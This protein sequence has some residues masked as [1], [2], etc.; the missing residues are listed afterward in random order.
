MSSENDSH[1]HLTRGWGGVGE[2]SGLV[3]PISSVADQN[4]M[5]ILVISIAK[6]SIWKHL[7]TSEGCLHLKETAEG[8]LDRYHLTNYQI[9]YKFSLQY[10]IFKNVRHHLSQEN[11]RARIG[12]RRCISL[13]VSLQEGNNKPAECRP[14]LALS[15]PYFTLVRKITHGKWSPGLRRQ[16]KIS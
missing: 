1:S 9:F 7:G 3:N 12:V 6:L 11:S 15:M 14:N 4:C 2:R 13:G 10:V 16:L 5:D 8:L